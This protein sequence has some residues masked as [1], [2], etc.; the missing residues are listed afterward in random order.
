MLLRFHNH[1]FLLALLMPWLRLASCHCEESRRSKSMC[2]SCIAGS[3]SGSMN[4]V[5]AKVSVCAG[6]ARK[7]LLIGI[8]LMFVQQWSGESR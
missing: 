2:L 3:E 5:A 4:S 1:I 7:A 8:G 6:T